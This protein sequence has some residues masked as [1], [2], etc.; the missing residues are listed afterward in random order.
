[1]VVVDFDHGVTVNYHTGVLLN[2]K[3]LFFK[4]RTV[5]L[6]FKMVYQTF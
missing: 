1:M 4:C 6:S 5:L 2:E 3:K